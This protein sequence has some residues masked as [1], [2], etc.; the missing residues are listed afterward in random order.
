MHNRLKELMQHYG[1]TANAFARKS[2]VDPSNYNKMLSGT[3][4]ISDKTIGKIGKTWP[5]VNIDWLK[6]GQ[7]SMLI[8]VPDGYVKMLGKPKVE[9]R[10]NLIDVKYYEVS[11]TASFRE[12]C[13]GMQED[14]EYISILPIM[15]EYI[16]DSYCVFKITGD[17]MA[18][19]IQNK[20]MVLCREVSPTRWHMLRDDVVVIA[21]GYHFVIKRIVENCLDS[22]NYLILDSDNPEYAEEMKV[23]LADIRCIF[24]AERI[25]LQT[26][27]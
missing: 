15:G 10:E 23:S 7:G 16:D 12:Y 17:S 22:K 26:I 1:L 9:I 14:P 5:E 3:Q 20:A 11:P 2:G 8:D 13:Q 18:P 21:Y 4:K 25:L 24:R 6:T 27:Y 19:Q